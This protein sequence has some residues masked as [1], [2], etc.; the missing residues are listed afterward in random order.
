MSRE[1]SPAQLDLEWTDRMRWEDLP[2]AVRERVCDRL[3]EVLRQVAR[4]SAEPGG[5]A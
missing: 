2:A 1:R 5:E 3:V 4:A